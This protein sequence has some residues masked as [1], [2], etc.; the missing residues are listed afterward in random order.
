MTA[1]LA[2]RLRA[3]GLRFGDF[4]PSQRRELV[5]RLPDTEEGDVL[6][7]AYRC[8]ADPQTTEEL[9]GGS[10][11]ADQ[12]QDGTWN[13][14]G[15]SIMGTIAKGVRRNKKPVGAAWMRQAVLMAQARKKE[16][17]LAPLHVYHHEDDGQRAIRAGYF[18]LT[19]VG[20]ARY[21]GKE[22]PLVFADFLRIP[23]DIFRQI[24]AGNLPY[25][26]V[27]VHDW[28]KPEINSLA[29]LPDE[30]PFFR[31]EMLTVNTKPGEAHAPAPLPKSHARPPSGTSI[32]VH[33]R[34]SGETAGGIALFRLEGSPMTMR[35]DPATGKLV[36]C[37]DKDDGVPLEPEK[38]E[39]DE[40]EKS[41]D[42]EN[43]APVEEKPKPAPA[44]PAPTEPADK[45]VELDNSL[46]PPE[47][48]GEA[49][50]AWAQSL[51]AG[52]SKILT[53]L[54][55]TEEAPEEDSAPAE[56][57]VPSPLKADAKL[58][59]SRGEAAAL[60]A[61]HRGRDKADSLRATVKTAVESLTA[62]GYEIDEETEKDLETFA[63]QGPET[64]K[65]YVE[66]FARVAVQDPPTSLEGL[67]ALVAEKDP[68]IVKTMSA[69]GPEAREIA[70]RAHAQAKELG[71]RLTMSAD[72]FVEL[73]V[74]RELA[75]A[76][77]E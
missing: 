40:D 30:V 45:I 43:V 38:L 64:L 2:E 28:T 18:M 29:L 72:R 54:S 36:K 8:A 68:A 76:E 50:P 66:S 31:L 46:A 60:R 13:I 61:K 10:Y 77:A 49:A 22:T 59:A 16:R 17:Y 52:L 62:K 65:A 12:N 33:S 74:E 25:R 34:L 39:D 5:K 69:R 20:M 51:A 11:T 47:A 73:E 14:R 23:E 6:A 70:L 15:V 37:A 4:S 71:H 55:P 19:H 3:V 35:I 53:L 21:E 9:P 41:D 24:E 67:E 63:A 75:G 56:E 42:L 26:S 7:A 44:A 1:K 58:A 27:E 57:P 32:A 48:A